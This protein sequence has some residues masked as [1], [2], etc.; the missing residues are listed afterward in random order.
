[1]KEVLVIEAT[2]EG[3]SPKQ[4][5]DTVTVSELMEILGGYNPDTEIYLSHD[6]G[7]T[8]GGIRE[9]QFDLIPEKDEDY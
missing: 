5:K 6:G 8:Y 9:D 1:M 2:R 4:V 3:Y 7:Y